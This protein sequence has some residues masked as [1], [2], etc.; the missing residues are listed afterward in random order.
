MNEEEIDTIYDRYGN[1]V[2]RLLDDNRL[3]TFGG[4]SIG[5][6][7]GINIYNYKGKHIGWLENGIFTDHQGR[8]V[9]FGENATEIS[10]PFLPY[11]QSKPLPML[12]ELEPLRPLCELEP[13]MPSK[14]YYWSEYE[15]I[16][17]FNLQQ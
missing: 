12:V 10:A 14:S 7:S 1:P 11:K 15:P 16:H 3:V 8:C 5:F 9:G 2:L 6:L 17:I 13:F 4:K